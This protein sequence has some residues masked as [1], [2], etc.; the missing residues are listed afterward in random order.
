MPSN[1]C[2][3][4]GWVELEALA[5]A[6]QGCG[7]RGAS[8]QR[9]VSGRAARAAALAA[10]LGAGPPLRLAPRPACARGRAPV[11]RRGHGSGQDG[12]RVQATDVVRPNNLGPNPSRTPGAPSSRS[13]LCVAWRLRASRGRG[14]EGRKA[15]ARALRCLVSSASPAPRATGRRPPHAH[16]ARLP[17][18]KRY[19]T[20]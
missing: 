20:R 18:R 12:P 17:V 14:G 3:S 4:S 8:R 19:H 5:A 2:C 1:T 11:P 15:A 6:R 10:G 13:R 9:E 7:E 16:P